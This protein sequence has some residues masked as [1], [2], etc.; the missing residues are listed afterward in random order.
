[1]N[2]RSYLSRIKRPSRYLGREINST[3][4]D[5]RAVA[6][7]V[8][9]LFPDLYEVGMSHLG[10]GLLLDILNQQED[11]WAE[12]AYAPAPDLEAELRSR[13]QPLSS[14]ESG[15]PLRDFDFLGVSLQYELGYTNFLTMLDLGGVPLAAAA[16]GPDDPVVIGG[17]P[18]AFNP[19]PVAPFFDALVLGDGEEAILELAQVIKDWKA[20]RGTRP[21][22]WHVLEGLEGVYV[23]ALFDMNFDAAGYLREIIPRGRRGIIYKRI[24]DDLNQAFIRPRPLVPYCQIIHDRLNVEISRGC[25]R[26]CRYCQ[27]GI[28]YRPVREWRPEAVQSWVETALAATGYEEVSLLS[29][30]PGDYRPLP[31]LL[32]RLMDSLAPQCVALS[33]PSLRA[34][35][36]SPEMV[37]QIQRVRRTGLTIAPEAG[38]D[39]L[40]QVVNKNLTEEEIMASASRAFEAGWQ[41]LKLYF[42][43]GLPTET[44]ED[45]EAI[46]HLAQEILKAGGKGRRPRLNVSLSTFIPKP[47]TPFQWEAQADLEESRRRLHEVKDRLHHQGI[48]I[49]WNAV[50]QSWLEGIFSRGDR[51]LAPVLLAAYRRGCRLDAW[52]EHLRLEPWR[53]AFQ[54]AG[55]D[56][57]LY[58]RPRAVAE[59]LPWSHLDAGVSREFLLD[60]RDRAYQGVQTPDCR[61]AGCQNCGVCD[62]N[63]ID[64]RLAEAPGTQPSEAL[65]RAAPVLESSPHGD[66]ASPSA[67]YRL[68]FAKLDDARWLSHLEL[69]SAF[70]RSLRRS[71]LPLSFSSGFHPLPRVA[72]HGALPVGV[73]SLAETLDLALA[74]TLGENSISAQLNEALPPGLKIL[75]VQHLPVKR[76][77]PH[78][79]ATLYQVLSPEPVFT[80]ERASRFL[81]QEEVWVM[82]QRPKQAKLVEVRRLVSKVEVVNPQ[83][84]Q[85][86]LNFSEK[87]NLKAAEIIAAIFG[88]SDDQ[89]TALQILK[90]C[91]SYRESPGKAEGAEPPPS[92]ATA[93]RG[94]AIKGE[95]SG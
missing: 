46:A 51:R 20:A 13:K 79:E 34:D 16:R 39:R 45:R 31:W 38:S 93:S 15:T 21:E 88:L 94:C 64:L 18:T 41:L 14:L 70:Y 71:G 9:L 11:I 61:L 82:R 66:R 89:S 81:S 56:P 26:G 10:L 35:T 54:D 27:A 37:A 19:E 40:R 25:T 17:G 12:R 55:V 63:Q 7:R 36:L 32:S 90:L 75:Q 43:I 80:K 62:Q 57:E 30:S 6:L 23:P 42:M 44:P 77:P 5:P 8:A 28:I 59:Q 74:D 92:L 68:T 47:H 2:D 73:E 85:I 22:L 4:K 50:A 60:E 83:E 3:Y 95:E 1:L 78:L 69:V 86:T 33:L 48:Q 65:P 58:L 53:L 29:L 87:D 49:K 24:L 72:F 84:V 67:W 91:C 52:S 76:K